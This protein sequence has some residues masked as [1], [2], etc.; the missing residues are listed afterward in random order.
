MPPAKPAKA[1]AG[2]PKKGHCRTCG[3]K[4][5]VPEGWTIGS[6]AR[7]H[8]W[9]KHRDVMLPDAAKDRGSKDRR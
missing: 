3:K 2:R 6:A 1:R 7:R 5:Y 9:R 4:I 8:Y